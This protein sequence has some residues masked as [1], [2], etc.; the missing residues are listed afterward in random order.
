MIQ[1]IESLFELLGSN[2]SSTCQNFALEKIIGLV[3]TCWP[4]MN[5]KLHI[6]S[7]IVGYSDSA[8]ETKS[9]AALALSKLH[10]CLQEYDTSVE[11]ALRAIPAF[12]FLSKDVFTVTVVSK[13]VDLYITQK[14]TES[15]EVLGDFFDHLFDSW[16][17]SCVAATPQ[18][19][20]GLAI[21]ARRLDLIK[22]VIGQCCDSSQS[23]ELISQCFKYVERFVPDQNFRQS[24]LQALLTT[25]KSVTVNNWY[26]L[27]Q[28]ALC[29]EDAEKVASLIVQQLCG[30]EHTDELISLQ[31]ALEIYE[32]TSL[33]FAME[34]SKHVEKLSAEADTYRLEVVAKIKKILEGEVTIKM[35][36]NFLYSKNS[37][38]INILRRTKKFTDGKNLVLHN[39]LVVSNSFMHYGTTVDEFLRTNI[40]W[41]GKA[42]HWAK[43][44]AV[45]S[46]GCIYKGNPEPLVTVLKAYL[47]KDEAACPYQEG[48]A[49]LA[50]GLSSCAFGVNAHAT[51]DG[52]SKNIKEYIIDTVQSCENKPQIVHGGALALGQMMFE[53]CDEDV[54]NILFS[55][56]SLSDAQ[57]GESCAVGIGLLLM[58]SGNEEVIAS[59]LT[60]AKEKDQKEKIVRG[61][62][63]A[64]ALILYRKESRAL[65]HAEDLLVDKNMWVR[66]GGCM[67]IALAFAGVPNVRAV[68]TLLTTAVKDT[69]DD[70]RRT[71]LLCVGFLTFTNPDM[72]VELLSDFIENHNMHVR[73]GVALALGI[74]GSGS[75]NTTIANILWKLFD[76]TNDFVRQGSVLALSMVLVQRS[77]EDTPIVEEFRLALKKKVEDRH[78]D[79]CTKFGCIIAQGIIDAGGQ[80][81]TIDLSKYNRAHSSSIAAVFLFSQHWFWFP[82]TLMLSQ[83]FS[84]R[85]FIGLNKSLEM[86]KC[87]LCS[88]VPT[89][90]FVPF[91]EEEGNK[92]E[93]RKSVAPVE[94]STTKREIELQKS[95]SSQSTEEDLAQDEEMKG[96]AQ[97]E[98]PNDVKADASTVIELSN[99]CRLTNEMTE[100]VNIDE[101]CGFSAIKPNLQGICMIYRE[102]NPAESETVELRGNPLHD[103]DFAPPEDF[104]L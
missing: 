66:M 68:E 75:G 76:D 93:E 29:F 30:K 50:L 71:A 20:L 2:H 28:C 73:Y 77:P 39:A 37:A 91:K 57:S 97:A 4:E 82:Y 67:I 102:N 81:C 92:S 46:L 96:G 56:L 45:A 78:V 31:M 14:K 89:S 58:G 79:I 13:I 94:L 99:P 15:S 10:F 41:L 72:A 88:S 18:E 84:V 21:Q 36:S 11:Y 27:L 8:K 23:S 44:S 34:V 9:L 101:S 5:N 60:I 42:S 49:L 85:C 100:I 54:Y 59:L 26:T 24:V 3:D 22:K 64:I 52:K 35:H 12:N 43:F 61:I 19:M 104:I 70:V 74:A 65:S 17:V 40:S 51:I 33:R 80:N 1:P 95:R 6:L 53:T 98:A 55:N 16:C 48:G 63:M 103:N 38:D 83:S 90:S 69:S 47:P 86:P 62:S 25:I 7:G 87:Q 32:S